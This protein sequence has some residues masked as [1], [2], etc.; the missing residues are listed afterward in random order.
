MAHVVHPMLCEGVEARAYQLRSLERI[1]S[2]ST[3]MVMPTGFGKTAVEWM[4]MAEFLRLGASK[5]VLIAPTTGLVDQQV[6][7]AKE[8]LN[9]DEEQITAYTGG[10]APEKRQELWEQSVVVIATPQVIRNDAMSGTINLA[11]VDLL[12]M[13]EAHHATGN[14][15][16]AQVGQLYRRQHPNGRVLAATASP[17]S[18]LRNINE[19]RTN[20]GVFNLDLS[21]RSDPLMQRYDVDMEIHTHFLD[22]PET[23]LTLLAPL[24]THFD[25]EVAHLQRQGFLAPKEHIGTKDIE[26]AQMSASRAIQQRDVRGYDAAR[27]V[28]DLRRIHMLTNLIQT[29]GTSM[30]AAFLDRAEE[31]GRKG[32]KTN[33]MLSL[34]TIHQLRKAL[35]DADELHPKLPLVNKLVKTELNEKPE[36]KVLIFTEYRDSVSLLVS[37]LQA[38]EGIKPDLFI[39]QSSRGA[40]KGMTQKQQLEQLKRFREGEINVLVAT[41]VGEEGLDVPAADLVVLYEPVPSAVRA[42]QRRGRT[43]RQRAGSVHMLITK[44]SRDAY[45]YRASLQQEENMHRLMDRMVRHRNLETKEVLDGV[46]DAFSVNADGAEVAAKTFLDEALEHHRP[47]S[48][49]EIETPVPHR[50]TARRNDR[51]AAPLTP[52]QLRP[53]TQ[54][55]LFQFPQHPSPDPGGPQTKDWESSVVLDAANKEIESLNRLK[56]GNK[57]IHIDH[58]EANSTLPAY[59]NGLG[60]NT[61]LTRLPWGDIRLSERVLIERKTARD[62]LASIK[63]GRLLEQCRSLQAHARRPLLLVETGGDGHYGLHPNSALGAMAHITLDLGIPVMMVRDAQEAAHFVGIAAKREHDA[64]ER[65]HN[66]VQGQSAE[67]AELKEHLE[68]AKEAVQELEQEKQH[69]WFDAKHEHLERCF[70]HAIEPIVAKHP[71]LKEPIVSFSPNLGALFAS[72]PDQIMNKA[73]CNKAVAT[74]L[75]AAL[76]EPLKNR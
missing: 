27:R 57:T 3:L 14:H 66:Y 32:R 54:T 68:T 29:Q 18:S 16:Y 44:D 35:N 67:G 70:L 38:H 34:P 12:I 6:S 43:A 4:A 5:I 51:V 49:P 69:P 50:Q 20:L 30:A 11:S 64:L 23:V 33:R 21:K 47:A 42:I 62:L 31:E 74:A 55:G 25:A 13:D 9:I 1:L 37:A 8:R 19:V 15:A 56:G 65:L 76:N 26:R 48:Q 40:Q 71:E 24:K 59:L 17:G 39:G 2:F 22:L 7:M 28:A 75:L 36:G 73:G 72:T 61:V 53:K 46:L 52:E 41:S 10:T 60:F 58:R 63:N 45:V